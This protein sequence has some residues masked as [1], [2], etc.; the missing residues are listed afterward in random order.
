MIAILA[1]LPRERDNPHVFP[2]ARDGRGCPTWPCSSCSR[3]GRQRLDRARLPV[4]LPRLG[5]EQTNYPRELAEAA[6]AHVAQ[7][8]DRGGLSARRPAG[9]AAPADGG[10]GGLLRITAWGRR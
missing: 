6:L 9:E 4:D 5:A 3:H 8:Q 7:G 10:M 1:A 2:G